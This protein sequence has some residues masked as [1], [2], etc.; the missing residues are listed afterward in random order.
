MSHAEFIQATEQFKANIK[1]GEF[2]KKERG[3]PELR[4]ALYQIAEIFQ[5]AL[6]NTAIN[7]LPKALE[8]NAM[9]IA[10]IGH[11][12]QNEK[13]LIALFSYVLGNYEIIPVDS[14]VN[15]TPT[16]NQIYLHKTETEVHYR[17]LNA[18]HELE[19][20]AVFLEDLRSKFKTDLT[21][22]KHI[23]DIFS[24]MDK[25][26][27]CGL[28]K[29]STHPAKQP[30]AAIERQLKGRNAVLLFG[31]NLFY[32]NKKTKT[33]T[34]IQRT[35]RNKAK[36]DHVLTKFT[37]KYDTANEDTFS[38]IR[39]LIRYKT[40]LRTFEITE[41]TYEIGM[42][43]YEYFKNIL[44]N[45]YVLDIL[46]HKVLVEVFDRS[47]TIALTDIKINLLRN[48]TTYALSPILAT[49]PTLPSC[50]QQATHHALVWS[51][52]TE[53]T[54][55][56]VREYQ[57]ALRTFK[58]KITALTTSGIVWP[59]N[60]IATEEEQDE[61]QQQRQDII[62]QLGQELQQLDTLL[63]TR[64]DNKEHDELTKKLAQLERYNEETV[65]PFDL[66]NATKELLNQHDSSAFAT[67]QNALSHYSITIALQ[68][69]PWQ[70][71]RELLEEL[72]HRIISDK[73]T[74]T[75]S[76]RKHLQ[77]YGNPVHWKE[78]IARDLTLRSLNDI[79]AKLLTNTKRS[80]L[81]VAEQEILATATP[82]LRDALA[83]FPT[84]FKRVKAEL[85]QK[86]AELPAI[87]SPQVIVTAEEEKSISLS[88]LVTYYRYANKTRAH[89]FK[90]AAPND[91][92]SLQ[93]YRGDALKAKILADFKSDLEKAP[94]SAAR[95]DV[96]QSFKDS[97]KYHLLAKGQ[98]I[99]TRMF[100]LK[101]D[102]LIAFTKM[103]DD[104][105]LQEGT[106]SNTL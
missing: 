25:D 106:V 104:V 95:N 42:H 15:Q 92:P 82:E 100:H 55:N 85:R 89:F 22:K 9:L 97:P 12:R 59:E 35:E 21:N 58:D 87:V 76:E 39:S 68:L 41:N 62:E 91:L 37:Q 74:F 8:T 43:L 81:S 11:L 27:K 17:I 99:C 88:P 16:K 3:E 48:I 71:S 13:T 93:N 20:G 84:Y 19:S 36:Y 79:F 28:I 72:Y 67:A 26:G 94:N 86:L 101:T 14:F 24:I 56:D 5:A 63:T 33:I 45:A 51:H 98:G 30:F 73:P 7:R 44:S 65:E 4:E 49:K 50:L 61:F 38:S 77:C 40:R 102:S 75:R 78:N 70:G 57:Q 18:H 54:R 31:S 46:N 2:H 64:T 66:D 34:P 23:A 10:A 53:E 60:R 69:K 96:I 103:C 80:E 52:V 90:A 47:G 105:E 6:T 32:A 29:V 1:Q 83:V